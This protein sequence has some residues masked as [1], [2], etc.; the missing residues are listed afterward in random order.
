MPGPLRTTAAADS[1]RRRP[2]GPFPAA[3][4]KREAVGQGGIC[5]LFG[6]ALGASKAYDVVSLSALRSKKTG[7][8][9]TRG[10]LGVP[11]YSV[12]HLVLIAVTAGKAGL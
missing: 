4:G 10:A 12:P 1:P 5:A 6:D 3:F 2:T 7:G 8:Q 9:G 11:F